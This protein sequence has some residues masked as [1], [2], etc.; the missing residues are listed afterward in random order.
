MRLGS[1]KHRSASGSPAL[2]FGSGNFFHDEIGAAAGM[3]RDNPIARRL[4][5]N[6]QPGNGF[7]DQ[8]FNSAGGRTI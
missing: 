8:F 1:Q 2:R 7:C 4:L 6:V 5:Y 3:M